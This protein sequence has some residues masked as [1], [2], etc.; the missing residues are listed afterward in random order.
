MIMW[1]CIH[2]HN[3]HIFFTCAHKKHPPL[4]LTDKRCTNTLKMW[5][6][7]TFPQARQ[8]C[9]RKVTVNSAVQDWHI[10]TRRSWI[11]T[12]AW[13][14]NNVIVILSASSPRWSGKD[15]F[16]LCFSSLSPPQYLFVLVIFIF[17]FYFNFIFIVLLP[18]PLSPILHFHHPLVSTLT[19]QSF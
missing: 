12:G 10:V 15:W 8:W 3:L 14:K 7:Q 1:Y 11:H 17:I 18:I 16:L 9:R 5:T 2:L 19:K 13:K 4:S 6:A